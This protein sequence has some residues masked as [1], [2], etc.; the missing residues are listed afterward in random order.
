MPLLRGLKPLGGRLDVRAHK[1][2]NPHAS[3]E[4]IETNNP[5]I[6]NII[7]PFRG[8]NPHASIERIETIYGRFSFESRQRKV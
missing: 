8:L 5:S 3:I 1:G 6:F 2:L 7:L 4:R